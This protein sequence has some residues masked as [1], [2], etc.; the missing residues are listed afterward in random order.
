MQWKWAIPK[1]HTVFIYRTPPLYVFLSSLT[2]FY[3]D[4]GAR[5]GFCFPSCMDYLPGLKESPIRPFVKHRIK[6]NLKRKRENGVRGNPC[7]ARGRGNWKYWTSPRTALL[8]LWGNASESNILRIWDTDTLHVFL[9]S[10]TSVFSQ[11]LSLSFH[12]ISPLHM[13]PNAFYLLFSGL[14][15]NVLTHGKD[16]LALGLVVRFS[17][18]KFS[19]SSQDGTCG[20]VG[21]HCTLVPHQR[22]GW[23]FPCQCPVGTA[24]LGLKLMAKLSLW[25][26]CSYI[27]HWLLHH[28]VLFTLRRRNVLGCQNWL[29][30]EYFI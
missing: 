24:G 10:P 15:K 25:M 18:G 2:E 17:R 4:H 23:R 9:L 6:C 8:N 5:L 27:D 30:I 12:K 20:C 3:T 1:F 13:S 19:G 22:L 21:S 16:F 11:F 26:L 29:K 7:S 28:F 14:S